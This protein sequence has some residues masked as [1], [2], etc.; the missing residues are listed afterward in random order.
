M[1]EEEEEVYDKSNWFEQKF[2][3]FFRILYCLFASII[4]NI[5][6]KQLLA[7]LTVFIMSAGSYFWTSLCRSMDLQSVWKI[8]DT[9]FQPVKKYKKIWKI[10]DNVTEIVHLTK[11]FSC[12]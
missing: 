12:I 2:S 8:P 6:K 11:G 10:L 4:I 1:L 9:I 7:P 5:F 3:K